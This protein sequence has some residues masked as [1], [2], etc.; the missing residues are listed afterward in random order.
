MWNDRLMHLCHFY[1][2]YVKFWMEMW[3]SCFCSKATLTELNNGVSFFPLLLSMYLETVYKNKLQLEITTKMKKIY[4]KR[5][6]DMNEKACLFKW[7]FEFH[8]RVIFLYHQRRKKC[9]FYSFIFFNGRI[10]NYRLTGEKI[11]K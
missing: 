8:P 11:N 5:K 9:P 4:I 7:T 3:Q 10:S 6:L 1:I 2:L